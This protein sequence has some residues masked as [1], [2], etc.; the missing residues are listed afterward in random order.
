MSIH[1]PTTWAAL[2][3]LIALSLALGPGLT[4]APARPAQAADTPAGRPAPQLAPAGLPTVQFDNS[5]YSGGESAGTAPFTVTLSTAAGITVTVVYTTVAGGTATAGADYAPAT[6]TLTFTPG[7]TA[8]QGTLTLLPDAWDEPD[9]TVFISLTPPSNADLGV[10]GFTR[11]SIL[12][13]DDP[14]SVVWEASTYTVSESAATALLTATLS[15]ASGFLIT[16]TYT[17]T[18]GSAAAGFDYIAVTQT[19]TFTAGLTNTQAI[20]PLLTDTADELDETLTVSLGGPANATLGAPSAATLTILDDDAPPTVQLSAALYGALESAATLP[21]TATLSAA[22]GLTVTVAYSTTPGTAAPGADYTPA[23]G[24]LTITPGLTTTQGL[25]ALLPDADFE[26]AET[27]GLSL[28]APANA[29]LGAPTTAT[30]IIAD[31]DT[32][33]TAQFSAAAYV[34]AEADASLPFTVTLSSPLGTLSAPS[35]V[36]V[37]V[38]YTTTSAGPQPGSAT[39]GDDYVHATG[40]LTFAPGVTTT[41]GALT[42]LPDTLYEPT[43]TFGLELGGPSNATLGTPGAATLYLVEDDGPPTAQ[44]SAAVYSAAESAATAPFTVTLS[45]AASLTITVAY[46]TTAGSAAPGADFVHTT[47][48]VTFSP[49]LTATQGGITLLP[50]LLD[51]TD[52]TVF[53]V[54]TQTTIA[55]LG[56]PATARLTILDDDAPPTVQW[57]AASYTATEESGMVTLSA[58]LSAASALTVTVAYSAAPDTALPGADYVPLSGTLTFAPGLT[59]QPVTLTL[60]NDAAPEPAESLTLALSGPANATLGAP[61]AASLTIVDADEFGLYLPLVVGPSAAA[62]GPAGR[63]HERQRYPALR[64]HLR[65]TQYR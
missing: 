49:G 32:P 24:T 20:V 26:P 22:G 11:F 15:A 34:A 29:A 3:W 6:G 48:V 33:P 1:S 57:S 18:A 8:T 17:T 28:S 7:L 38:A 4:P 50:D 12:D 21:F 10:P 42:L 56:A 2:R 5:N 62:S 41:V 23:T 58:A 43:E 60:T 39:P 53:V 65:H 44:F 59:Q 35:S 64:S 40:V 45:G 52:E 37:T 30:V 19:L 14:P 27:F 25:I 31:D 51:E 16:A 36:T 13:D 9:E 46:S 54:M 55:T 47:G 61:S 63:L